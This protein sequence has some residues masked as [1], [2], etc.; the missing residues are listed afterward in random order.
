MATQTVEFEASTGQTLTAKL[1]ALGS[2][3]QVASVSA[4]EATNRKSVYGAAYTDVAAG[5]YRLVAFAGATSVASWFVKLTLTTATF[6]AGNY[7]DVAEVT[8]GAMANNVLTAA[9]IATDALVGKGDWAKLLQSTTIAVVTSQTVFTLTAGSADNDAYNGA[10]CII[11][12]AVTA[13]QKAFVR[14]S[15]YVGATRTVTLESAPAFTIVATDSVAIVAG[16]GISQADVRAALGLASANL[17][18]QLGDLDT[19]LDF[20]SDQAQIAAQNTQS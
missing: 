8:V 9:A 20:A 7:A 2:D 15:D 13:V 14:V 4:T 11:S 5:T 12:D 10:I 17:D 16:S 18:T 1:F 3:V 6:R 19:N